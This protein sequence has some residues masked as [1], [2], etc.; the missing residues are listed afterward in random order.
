MQDGRLTLSQI[1]EAFNI[2]SVTK[3]FFEDYKA[4]FLQIKENLDQIVSSNQKLKAEFKRCNID[5]IN[6]AKKLLGQIVFLYFLQKKGW[7][8]V[9]EDAAWG[10]GDKKFLHKLYMNKG[11]R[12]FFD[13]I[14]EPF[15]YEALAIERVGDFYPALQCKVPFLNGGLF[16]PLNSY[17]WEN[18]QINLNDRVFEEIFKVFNLYN[19]TVREDEPL[20]REVAVDPEMLGK[21][22][23]NLLEIKDRKSKGAYYTPREI[24]H[25]MCQ[26]SLINYLDT[27]LNTETQKV[28]KED[29]ESFIREGDISLENDLAKEAGRK[30]GDFGLPESIREFA[31]EIDFTLADVKICDPAIGSG[32]FPVGMMTEIVRAR[33]VLTIHL[34]N[35]RNRDAYT[36][37]WHCIEN[38]LYGVDIDSSAVEIAKLRLWLSLVV[39]EESYDQIRPLPNLDY[40]IVCGNSLLSVQKDLFNYTLYP[41]LEKK[42]LQ[43]FGTT[44]QKNKEVLRREIENLIDQLTD[45]KELFDFEV[46]FSE[47]FSE[48][49]GFN[50]VIGNPPYFNV[51]TLGANSTFAKLLMKEYPDV[52]MDKSDILFFFIA[53]A[54]KISNST[55]TFIISNAFLFANKAKKLRNYILQNSKI[56]KIINFENFQVFESALIST[57]ILQIDK[58]TS[59]TI[60]NAL[61]IDDPKLSVPEFLSKASSVENFLQVEL[62]KDRVF[63]LIDK[64]TN[65]LCK[66]IDAKNPLLGD[67]FHVGSGMQTGAN[68]VFEFKEIPIGFPKEYFRKRVTGKNI[69]KY[70]VRNEGSYLLYVEDR[71]FEELPQIIQKYLKVNRKVLANRA[72]K[73]RRSSSQWWNYTF[74][75]HKEYYHL[76]KIWCSY[77]NHT[78][79][80]ALDYSQDTIGL[81]N[82]S[83]IF[84]T[85]SK[86]PIE[87]LIA[88][89]NSRLITYRYKFI[90]K[91]TGNNMYEY[92]PNGLSKIPIRIDQDKF[93]ILSSLVDK[94][95]DNL[96]DAQ[97]EIDQIV[98][99]LYGLTAEEVAIVEESVKL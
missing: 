40:R 41:E 63:A 64:R 98:Y 88:L 81:T 49:Q 33:N 67:L 44:S 34:Q 45:G 16:E 5:T 25:Y 73:Q 27:A 17:D 69:T 83:V 35:K 48:K 24:V 51:E 2:E 19:F 31:K 85:N 94:F 32:A 89:I 9:A 10:T 56:K 46:Y 43:Y 97:T 12:N 13:D 39:D 65:D 87:Y 42:K 21:V 4:L 66:K 72:D 84:D 96:I 54:I 59:S 37:K 18:T 68:Q 95:D 22:F 75:M 11:G 93:E 47:V 99:A 82:V 92:F 7:L 3:E 79:C 36:F 78:N 90:G 76:P 6:F 23:E 91:S 60:T 28:A 20:E 70:Q 8:G 80:F 29:I 53:K 86:V 1:E 58:G 55:V 61:I 15:F 38:S 30:S 74:A 14:L 71:E 77:R 57:A 62:N 52:W 50:V 26:E